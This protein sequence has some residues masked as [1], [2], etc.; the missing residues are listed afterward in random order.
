MRQV[1][2]AARMCSYSAP[3]CINVSP[4]TLAL[5]HGTYE[6]RYRGE[7]PVKGKGNMPLYFL[8]GRASDAMT[9]LIKEG[10]NAPM[11]KLIEEGPNSPPQPLPLL[12]LSPT[13]ASTHAV[14]P[15]RSRA[16]A[17]TRHQTIVSLPAAQWR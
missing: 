5:V 12:P 1:N 6:A 3:G 7:Q 11:T 15:P 8:T 13:T 14:A 2:T 16:I 4:T 17:G 9:K 10:P